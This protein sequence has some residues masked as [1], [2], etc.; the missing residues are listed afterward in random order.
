MTDSDV[1]QL[2]DELGEF[3]LETVQRLARI[4]AQLEALITAQTPG[5]GGPP[6]GADPVLGKVTMAIIEVLKLSVAALTAWVVAR[7][8]GGAP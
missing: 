8:T 2:R 4:E 7:S 6:S 1:R 5:R 3:K